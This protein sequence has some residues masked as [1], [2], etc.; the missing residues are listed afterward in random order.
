M[1][2]I[3][4]R[5]TVEAEPVPASVSEVD[6]VY[7]DPVPIF[8]R[9]LIRQG[10]TKTTWGESNFVIP[11]AYEKAPNMGVVVAASEHY[12]VDGKQ[13]PMADMVKPGDIVTFSV[14]NAEEIE[15]D[16]ERFALCSIFDVKLIERVSYAL[17]VSNAG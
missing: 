5:K 3:D 11:Q 4:R 16:G 13:F 12:I 10:A 17:G 8:D 6:R 2:I 14:I 1:E 15:R 9:I 7:S